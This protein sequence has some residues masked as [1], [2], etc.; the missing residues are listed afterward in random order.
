LYIYSQRAQ[1]HRKW[2][3]PNH[4]VLRVGTFD[5]NVASNLQLG[6]K[7]HSTRRNYAVAWPRRRSVSGDWLC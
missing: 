4:V 2:K 6:N 5:V 7:A 3:L 1:Q